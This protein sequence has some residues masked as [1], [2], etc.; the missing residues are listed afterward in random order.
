MEI[1][2]LVMLS[3]T[4]FNITHDSTRIHLMHSSKVGLV[5]RVYND[6]YDGPDMFSNARRTSFFTPA[7][8]RDAL[9]R[10]NYLEAYARR[11]YGFGA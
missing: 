11:F 4:Q 3:E 5:L 7:T 1:S 8:L 2:D 9:V 6:I 10:L